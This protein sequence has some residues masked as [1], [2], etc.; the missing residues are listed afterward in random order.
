[1]DTFLVAN[2][3]SLTREYEVLSYEKC[4]FD[5]SLFLDVRIIGLKQIS[6]M[7]F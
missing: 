5:E 2:E 4:E 3:K 1:V 6:I 7:W